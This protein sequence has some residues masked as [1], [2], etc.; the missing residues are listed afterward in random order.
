MFR[1]VSVAGGVK[2]K[3]WPVTL[4]TPYIPTKI[5]PF[6][7]GL[8]L[9]VNPLVQ[10][11]SVSYTPLVDMELLAVAYAATGYQDGDYWE[12]IIGGVTIVETNYTKEVAELV[13]MGPGMIVYP[14]AAGTQISFVF[15]NASGT[16]K[17]VW[18][19]FRLL[20]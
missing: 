6:T 10:S 12:L 1:I 2:I 19:Q 20:K 11:F 7:K 17:I 18:P 3:N 9:V 8:R 4:V 5:T 16:N 13:K 14:V 15:Q